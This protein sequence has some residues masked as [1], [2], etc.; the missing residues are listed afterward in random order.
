MVFHGA[1]KIYF[2]E[3]SKETLPFLYKPTP[4]WPS[5]TKTATH[6]NRYESAYYTIRV[7]VLQFLIEK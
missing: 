7:A 4:F 5:A 1:K 2:H 6:I 3:K